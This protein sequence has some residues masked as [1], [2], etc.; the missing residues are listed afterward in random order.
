MTEQSI[1]VDAPADVVYRLVAD[2]M[3]MPE[4]SPECVGCRWMAGSSRPEV[5]ARFRGTSR[6][7]RR[8]WST[9][10][11]ITEMR[12]GEVFAWEVTYF[13][14]PVARWEYRVEPQDDGVRLLE[15]VDDRRGR[16]LRAVSPLITG[17]RDRHTRNSD[18]MHTTLQ[19]VKDAAETRSA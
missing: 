15:T 3:R 13:R 4:W 8:R 19:A 17:A 2:P 18:T 12:E 14:Q 16:V 1:L 5:G 6:N 7:G 10:S 9:T 11:Q